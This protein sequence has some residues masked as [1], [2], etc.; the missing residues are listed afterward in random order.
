MEN[1]LLTVNELMELVSIV[2]KDSKEELPSYKSDILYNDKELINV[3][4]K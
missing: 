4:E 1:E 3:N 2:E